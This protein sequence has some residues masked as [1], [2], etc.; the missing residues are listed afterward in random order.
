MKTLRFTRLVSKDFNVGT[1]L[2]EILSKIRFSDLMV[3]HVGFSF[4]AHNKHLSTPDETTQIY[5]FCPKSLAPY[6][7]KCLKF[8]EARE[9]ADKLEQM[10]P[11]EHLENTFFATETGDPFQ[12]SGYVPNNLVCNYIWI[13]K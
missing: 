9:F 5:L 4:I 1:W 6:T 11:N 7:I 10:K 3:I 2:K 12:Q 13:S 8:S